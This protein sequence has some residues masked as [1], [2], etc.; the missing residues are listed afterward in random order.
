MREGDWMIFVSWNYSRI[1][2]EAGNQRSVWD[3]MSWSWS[4][5]D[6]VRCEYHVDAL[7]MKVFLYP[8]GTWDLF[9]T[10][11]GYQC[12]PFS[13]LV[14]SEVNLSS[15]MGVSWR[16]W[17]RRN[18]HFWW[19]III[20]NDQPLVLNQRLCYGTSLNSSLFSWPFLS[21]RDCSMD[22]SYDT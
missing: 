21:R 4:G 13:L 15:G 8:R 22:Y 11:K 9:Q 7:K 1:K 18:C 2:P 12:F 17:L 6:H 16:A 10:W 3:F 20:P 5:F 19:E 14:A